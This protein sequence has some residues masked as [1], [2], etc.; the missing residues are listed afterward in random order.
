MLLFQKQQLDERQLL[1]RGNIFKH[2]LFIVSILIFLNSMINIFLGFEWA[3]GRWSELTILLLAVT[4]CCIEFICYDIYPF[5]EKRQ[6]YLIYFLGAY[7]VVSICLCLYEM[8]TLN[9]TPIADGNLSSH[10]LGVL[11]GSMF[12]SIYITYTCKKI[13]DRK[14]ESEE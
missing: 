11:H 5:I 9:I 4:I 14:I 13:Y 7:G 3:S 12:L 8:I 10:I 1:I 6:K 2:G